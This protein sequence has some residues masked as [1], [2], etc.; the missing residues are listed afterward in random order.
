MVDQCRHCCALYVAPAAQGSVNLHYTIPD[1][2]D[3]GCAYSDSP[4]LHHWSSHGWVKYSYQ[5]FRTATEEFALGLR[6]QEVNGSASSLGS[7]RIGLLLDNDIYWALA[8]MGS[9]LAGWVTVPIDG[10]QSVDAISWI[11]K[12]SDVC[13]LVVSNWSTLKHVCDSL[14]QVRLIVVVDQ[15]LTPDWV[16]SWAQD[17][18]ITTLENLRCQG[19]RHHAPEVIQD[20]KDAIYPDALATIVYTADATGVAKGAMLS[21]RSLT[22]N[23][24]AAFTSM[25]GL[26]PG[27]SEVAL[28][29]LP[30]N[31]IFARTFLYGHFGF[32]HDIYFS[33]PKRVFRHLAM[34]KPTIFITVPRLLEKVYERINSVRQ[35][36]SG[37]QH[38]W[39]SW[40]WHWAHLYQ[41]SCENWRWYRLQRWVLG[42]GVFRNLHQAFGGNIRY[43]LS[44]GAAL[45]PEVMTFFNALG[46]PVRQGYGLTETSSVLSYTRDRWLRSGTVGAPIPGVEMRLAADGEVLVKSVYTMEGYHHNPAAT[47][48][49]IDADGWFHTG[50]LGEFS[51]DGLLTLRGCKKGLFK[52][53]TGK[54][55]APG[56]IEKQLERS[57][58]VQQAL[59]VGPGQKF[60]GV[61]IVPVV[62]GSDEKNDR[63]RQCQTLIDQVNTHLSHWSMIKRF[64]LVESK[65]VTGVRRERLYR[66]YAQE[67]DEL[68]REANAQNSSPRKFHHRWR[69]WER[70]RVLFHHDRSANIA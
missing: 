57:P 8:D 11:V 30:L 20:L 68:Y 44:G 26:V 6:A 23:I 3:M 12:D 21:H 62:D 31:H 2:L 28:S 18:V 33:S 45:R 61:L 67:I 40:G 34:V 53:S 42:Q 17:K 27:G 4:A 15:S 13:A 24:W 59:L 7:R 32:G 60:C 48:A 41:A 65:S 9:L 46:I 10:G 36:S 29:F 47:D 54:Y 55:V 14:H 37:W 49:V 1:L 43:L 50:D 22:G 51:V 35:Q 58:L 66:L 64:V 56:P 25:P 63:I 70:L 5:E 39:L 19:C 69:I 16:E 38:L 52:L